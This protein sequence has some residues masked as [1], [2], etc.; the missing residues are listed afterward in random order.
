MRWRKAAFAATVVSVSSGLLVFCVGDSNN[1]GP[2]ASTKDSGGG[3]DADAAPPAQG[4]T[5]TL[6]PTGI[7]TDPGDS[8]IKI[9][10]GVVRAAG[11]TDD[12]SFTITAPAHVT[13]TN[14]V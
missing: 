1:P 9:D 3:G 10:I 14:A 11:F 12:V 6:T 4:F 5:L 13:A 2:D 7:T 8:N